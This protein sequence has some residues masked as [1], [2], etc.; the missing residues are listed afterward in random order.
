MKRTLL[1]CAFLACV[2]SLSFADSFKL[3][4]GDRV[5]FYGDSITEQHLYTNYIET[6]IVTRYPNLKISFTNT[7]VG[8]DRVTGGWA[9][10]IDIRLKRDFIAHKPTVA[11]IMLGMNDASYQPFK[12]DIFDTY[13]NGYKKI[14]AELKKNLPG[15]QLFLIQPSPFDDFAH[16]PSWE[17]GYNGVLLRYA[18]YVKT[19]AKANGL[20]TI[21]FNGPIASALTKAMAIDSKL[22]PNLI[23]DRVH[24]GEQAQLLMAAEALK[25]WK[26]SGVVSST[27]IDL[28]A[29]KVV[30]A[31]KTKV[32]LGNGLSWKQ[33]DECLPF[34][35]KM[36]D[37]LVALAMKSSDFIQKL[38]QQTLKV[39]GLADGNYTLKIDGE[40]IGDYSSLQ[41]ASGINLALLN[42]PMVKQAYR[43]Q[44]FTNSH[45]QCFV[46]RW[47]EIGIWRG[48]YPSSAKVM[49]DLETLEKEQVEAQR[50]AAKPIEHKFELVKK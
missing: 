41:L 40:A 6:F 13:A 1:S 2:A 32:T 42:T 11:T 10:G 49:A 48:E 5:L 4:D 30:T 12:Q 27:E 17:G 37:Q 44:D 38:N 39:K 15:L 14:V 3:K 47:R 21:D 20:E 24:P 35:L 19:L 43:V 34:P 45:N 50:A 33:L 29:R 46:I 7:G 23:G 18:D 25:A 9:G 8:G 31:E 28:G 26:V 16:T 22:A 36:D